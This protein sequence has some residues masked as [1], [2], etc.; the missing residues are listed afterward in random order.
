MCWVAIDRAIKIANI[1]EKR[2]TALKWVPIKEAIKEDIENYA[3]NDEVQ[4]YTQSYGSKYIDASV[5][6]VS[7]THLTL[8]TKA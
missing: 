4:A 1:L 2:E 7:Y 8:P 5:L 6:P 3:W